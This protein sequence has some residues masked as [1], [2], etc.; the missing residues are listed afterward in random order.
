[1]PKLEIKATSSVLDKFE[2]KISRK[3][4]VRVEKRIVLLISYQV[5]EVEV[6][7]LGVLIHFAV[8]YIFRVGG[9]RLAGI[10]TF[11]RKKSRQDKLLKF[12]NILNHIM[13][14]HIIFC[15]KLF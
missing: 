9:I 10:R 14:L 13:S 4:V 2:R 11:W 8:W 6:Y 3:G 7:K 15:A 12:A 1:M 5:M